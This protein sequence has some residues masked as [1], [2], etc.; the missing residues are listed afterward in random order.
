MHPSMQRI[1]SKFS[2]RMPFSIPFTSEEEVYD[3]ISSADTTESVGYDTIPAKLIQMST[4]VITKPITN[5][6]NLS[7]QTGTYPELLKTATVTPVFR[8]E[9]IHF[10]RKT[11]D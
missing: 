11:T 4:G 10:P 9:K 3:I 1:K 8:I 2:D 5:I 6:I 7:I